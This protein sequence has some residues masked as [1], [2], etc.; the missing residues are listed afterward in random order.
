MNS[1]NKLSHLR[2]EKA[3]ILDKKIKETLEFLD[4]PKV[5]FYTSVEEKMDENGHAI[6]SEKGINNGVFYMS[7]NQGLD[8]QP[9]SKIASGGELSR[10]MLA[11]K[12]VIAAKEDTEGL[13]FDEIDSGVSGKT[14]RKIGLKMK[15][16]SK[17]QQIITVTH[18]AQIASLADCHY[19]IAKSNEN[20]I[21]ASSIL[22]LD[23]EGRI[24]ELSRILG[25]LKVSDAQRKA[26]ID[27][28]QENEF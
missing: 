19:L 17:N 2:S 10:V 27:M 6:L 4:M 3:L 1:A 25:G 16:L 9:L 18:S 23:Y 28:L 11:V 20:G 14:A 5:V 26:A 13:I 21:T 22:P 8:P 12:S 24:K 15:E 7:A